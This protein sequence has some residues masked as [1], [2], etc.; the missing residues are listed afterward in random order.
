MDTK[1]LS[2]DDTSHSS[3]PV[4]SKPTWQKCVHVVLV[5]ERHDNSRKECIA[6]KFSLIPM[7]L[8]A[9]QV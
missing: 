9:F 3:E 2:P 1:E 6:D 5:C 7:L 4:M 8:Q